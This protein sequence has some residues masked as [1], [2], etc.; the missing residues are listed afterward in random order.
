M[1]KAYESLIENQFKAFENM[2]EGVSVYKLIFNEKGEAVDA[3]LEYMN[4]ATVETMDLNQENAI[5][6][7]ASELFSLDYLNLIFQ[8]INDFLVTGKFK[9]FEVYYAPTDRYFIISGFNMPDDHF[10]VLRTDITELKHTEEALKDTRDNL[11]EKVEE[12]TAEL[13]KAY[14]SLKESEEKYKQ[15]FEASP[16]FTVHVG[17]NGKIIDANRA[18]L[19]ILSKSKEEL[20]G[21]NFTEIDMLFKEDIPIHVKNFL[22]LLVGTHVRPYETRIKGKNGEVRWGETYPIILRKYKIPNSI[23]VISHDITDRKRAEEQLKES[24]EKFRLIFDEAEDSIVLNEMKENGLPGKII[25]ANEA[26]TKRLGYTKEELL[27]MTP[28]DIVAPEMRAEMR[29]N[30]EEIRNKGYAIF[31]NIHMAKDGRRIP[32]EVNNHIMEFKGKK[33]ALT[34]VR[35]IT[36]RKKAEEQLKETIEELEHSNR[37]LQ[38]FAYIT[39][40]D[41]QE[42]LRTMGSYAGLLK[43]R[44]EGQLDSDADE[45]LDYMISGSE[46]MKEQIKGLLDYSRMGT[47]GEEKEFNAEEALE[48]ALTNLKSSI[49]ELSAEVTHEKLPNIVADESQI[50]RVF[51]NLISNALKFR[52]EGVKPKIHIKAK[53]ED[54]EYIFSISDNGIGLEPQ[55]S[56]QIFE[57]FKRLHA[58]GEY[59]GAGIG[60][61]IVKRIIDN[62]G[63]RVWVESDYGLGSTFYFT[64]PL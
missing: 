50:T 47:S 60:L 17:L 27:N 28:Q 8:A 41:L 9:R 3:K 63:G 24:E 55:Y 53:K 42:P 51:Q 5:G 6:K 43:R 11:E 58:I 45:F 64:I 35:D 16:N 19:E 31:E 56:D 33:I 62:H 30:A 7:N 15:F 26:T 36:E 14:E 18:A 38:S 46:R 32:V 13:K 4:H 2:L 29:K 54:N 20:I 37:D 12:R 44:Y 40:H 61:A 49:E 21:T 10:A 1:E 34:V 57:V 52:R 39:S 59:Q 22:K 25:E 23:L 48:T